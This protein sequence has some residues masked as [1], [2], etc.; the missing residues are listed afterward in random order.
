[1]ILTCNSLIFML[2][3]CSLKRARSTEATAVMQDVAMARETRRQDLRQKLDQVAPGQSFQSWKKKEL[4]KRTPRGELGR[5]ERR[6]LRWF[7]YLGAGKEDGPNDVEMGRISGL[8]RTRSI[9]QQSTGSI[10]PW[11]VITFNAS[12]TKLP[13]SY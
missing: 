4:A 12:Q 7:P 2:L 6:S 3:E 10:K 5:R 1:M 8:T 11:Y 13:A 9:G